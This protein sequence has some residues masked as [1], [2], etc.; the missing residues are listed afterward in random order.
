MRW[1][2]LATILALSATAP[3]QY[4]EVLR[5]WS[6]DSVRSERV[7]EAVAHWSARRHVDPAVVLGIVWVENRELKPRAVSHDGSVGIM[8]VQP[9]WRK[10][11]ARECGSD[12]FDIDTNV[13][14]GTGVYALAT[15][16]SATETEA[17]LRYNGC[18]R[19]RCSSYARWVLHAAAEVR[20]E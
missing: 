8:Q 2:V 15:K 12:L 14:Y 17:L 16:E 18:T 4:A 5:R 20:D 19:R 10:T 11:F 6:G 1:L 9:F 3:P 13:C 7:A